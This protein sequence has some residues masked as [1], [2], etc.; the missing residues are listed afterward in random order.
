MRQQTCATAVSVAAAKRRGRAR[1]KRESIVRKERKSPVAKSSG[2]ARRRC[3]SRCGNIILSAL[4]NKRK[5]CF[6]WALLS[7]DPL[8]HS[9]SKANPNQ[10]PNP[11]PNQTEA[12][13]TFNCQQAPS[14]WQSGE[15]A[16][17]G[18]LDI[19]SDFNWAISIFRHTES[20]SPRLPPP[21]V[22]LSRLSTHTHRCTHTDTDT[23]IVVVRRS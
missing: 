17:E 19:V 5:L 11:N 22:S 10:N 14:E 23:D 9:E 12:K 2:N 18:A 6:N 20:H 4:P 3:L 1:R 7:T 21:L 15:R 16:R 8:Q 13:R